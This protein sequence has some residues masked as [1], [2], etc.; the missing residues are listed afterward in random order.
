MALVTFNNPTGLLKL[1]DNRFAS[2]LPSGLPSIGV[3]G[4]GGRG[5]VSGGTLELSNVDMATEFVNMIVAQRGYQANSRIITT[6]DEILQESI[7]LKR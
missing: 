7:N 6:T 1:G 4:A 5:S 2:T 3:P